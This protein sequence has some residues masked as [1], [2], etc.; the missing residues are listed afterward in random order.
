M[1][2]PVRYCCLLL[3]LLLLLVVVLRIL[4]LCRR[5][6]ILLNRVPV[7]FFRLRTTLSVSVSLPVVFF[8]LPSSYSIIGIIIIGNTIIPAVLV[9]CD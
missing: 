5:R 3:L 8:F 2:V 7:R 4:R 9:Y 1:R 6:I